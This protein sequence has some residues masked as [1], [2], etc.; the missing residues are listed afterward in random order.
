M[1]FSVINDI[2]KIIETHYITIVLGQF[3]LFGVLLAF[4]QFMVNHNNDKKVLFYLGTDLINLELKERIKG[5][6]ITRH[7][8]FVVVLITE[9]ITIPFANIQLIPLGVSAIFK[10]FD[11]LVVLSYFIFMLFLFWGIS[12]YILE[13]DKTQNILPDKYIKK[14]NIKFLKKNWIK[15]QKG[16]KDLK[17]LVEKFNMIVESDVTK[18]NDDFLKKYQIFYNKLLNDI[19][20]EYLIIRKNKTEDQIVYYDSLLELDLL[21]CLVNNYISCRLKLTDETICR[22]FLVVFYNYFDKDNDLEKH[23]YKIKLNDFMDLIYSINKTAKINCLCLIHGRLDKKEPKLFCKQQ[24]NMNVRNE[25]YDLFKSDNGFEEFIT[26]FSILFREGELSSDLCYVIAEYMIKFNK[27]DITCLVKNL[28]VEDRFYIFSYWIMYYSQGRCC[29]YIH[30]NNLKSLFSRYERENEHINLK[31]ILT[32]LYDSNMPGRINENTIHK[33]YKYINRYI[34]DAQFLEINN[35]REFKMFYL[36]VIECC[37]FE[38]AYVTFDFINSLPIKDTIDLLSDCANHKEIISMGKLDSLFSKIKRH[39]I[40]ELPI[41]TI[42]DNIF[43]S[44]DKMIL[45]DFEL[46]KEFFNNDIYIDYNTELGQYA[47]IKINDNNREWK[48]IEGCIK[49]AFYSSNMEVEEYINYLLNY[50]LTFNKPISLHRKKRMLK[51]LQDHC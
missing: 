14:V 19:L 9:V 6:F 33:L 25:L 36:I 45:L 44:L 20:K 32:R 22:M 48:E 10:V 40:K 38:E 28:S 12:K 27:V 2:F 35:D 11:I 7:F 21:L 3:T 31:N 51:Y 24:I 30:I 41:E 49:K 23:Y 16:S 43:N 34:T 26:T 8:C 17:R 5:I 1:D 39:L 13:M 29:K 46:T 47:L 15:T 37:V 42:K 4:F 18:N 50:C